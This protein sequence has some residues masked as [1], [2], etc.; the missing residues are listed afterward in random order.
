MPRS[1]SSRSPKGCRI[2]GASRFC[3]AARCWSLSVPAGCVAR[4]DLRWVRLAFWGFDHRRHTGE[5]LV[6][7]SAADDMVEAVAAQGY[8]VEEFLVQ[9]MVGDGVELLV[10]VVHDASFG[11][12]V[13]CGAGGTAVELLKDVAVRITPLTYL[14]ASEMVLSLQTFPL[15]AVSTATREASPLAITIGT[16][17]AA[18]SAPRA[19]TTSR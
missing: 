3:P 4:A 5:L 9:R 13:A 16:A 14:D 17:A 11:P 7:A 15:R 6:N 2:R 19:R 18:R 8:P 10:G 12:V 1:T